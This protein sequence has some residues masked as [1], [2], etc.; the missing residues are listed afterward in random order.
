MQQ[1]DLDDIE[2]VK[3]R[4]GEKIAESQDDFRRQMQASIK[5]KWDQERQR[6]EKLEEL[7]EGWQKLRSE[8]EALK[9]ARDG[10]S[11]DRN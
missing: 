3:D 6:R 8:L 2:V 4:Q 7:H 1:L 11:Y 5:A 9:M 10:K